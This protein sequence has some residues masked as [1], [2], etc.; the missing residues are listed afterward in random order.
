MR[1]AVTKL[2]DI[3]LLH[4]ANSF[5][6]GK[7]SKM[8]LA[9][10]YA[11][12]HSPIRSQIFWIELTD[13]PLF[14]ASQFVRSHVGVQPF[15]RSKRTDRGG[16]DFNDVCRNIAFRIRTEHISK[17]ESSILALVD[18]YREMADA[19]ETLPERFDR[20]APTD[21]AFLINAEAIINMSHKR[22]CCKASTETREIWTAVIAEIAKVDPDLAKHCVKPCVWRGYCSEAKSCGFIKTDLYRRQRN[23]YKLLFA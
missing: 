21:L 7:E 23:D 15:Q 13:I 11:S 16:E 14:C 8:S 3:E 9:K 1:V 18:G 12:G 10:A 5:T 2:T 6:T 19:V 22:L 17:D 4:K 20:Y